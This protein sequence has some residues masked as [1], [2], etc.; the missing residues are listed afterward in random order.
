ML[1]V[2]CSK[3]GEM[4]G[5]FGRLRRDTIKSTSSSDL[6]LRST[7]LSSS[8]LH[9]SPINRQVRPRLSSMTDFGCV[10]LAICFVLP[11]KRWQ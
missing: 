5:S 6:E 10:D 3:L 9:Q 2:L 1:Y 11:S 8:P 7:D 4:T